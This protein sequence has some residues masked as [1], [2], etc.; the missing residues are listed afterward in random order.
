MNELLDGIEKET[1]RGGLTLS[2]RARR[3][4]RRW[5]S[6][7]DTPLK[8]EAYVLLSNWFLTGSGD[9]HSMVAIRCEALWDELFPCRPAE[10]LSSSVAGRNHVMGAAEFE[11]FWQRLLAAGQHVPA[12]AGLST[13]SPGR[14]C[15]RTGDP[16]EDSVGSAPDQLRARFDNN[17]LHF[18]V[19]GSA[20]AIADFLRVYGRPPTIA[21]EPK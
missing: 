20:R 9:R 12:A 7:L 21:E 19:E 10:R 6:H 8:S 18:E 16:P 1:T 2:H 15:P 14:A 13:A 4:F 5:F 11:G 3:E 17:G